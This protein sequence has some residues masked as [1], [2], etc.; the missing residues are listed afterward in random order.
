VRAVFAACAL[1]S[2]KREGF[3]LTPLRTLPCKALPDDGHN[4]AIILTAIS[5]G[6]EQVEDLV[7]II[8]VPVSYQH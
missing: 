3:H 6:C 5:Q 8:S 7:E 2:A 4:F 1:R